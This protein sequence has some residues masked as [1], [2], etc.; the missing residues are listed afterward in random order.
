MPLLSPNMNVMMKAAEKAAKSLLRD[1]G[2]VENLQVSRKG[3]GDF[4]SAAD[5]RSEKIIFEELKKA[6]PDYGFLMEE[7]GKGESTGKE[8]FRWI[9]D[10]LDGTTNFLHGIPHWNITIALEYKD[11][12][13]AGLIFDPV[14]NELFH[15]EKGA[16]AFLRNQRLR[17]SSRTNIQ[18]AVLAT[19]IPTQGGSAQPAR[20]KFLNELQT[21]MQNQVSGVRRMGAAAL[22]MAYV[23]A[24]RY[25]GYWESSI[26]AWDV[27]AGTLIVREAGGFASPL[28]GEGSAVHSGS[29][30][31]ANSHLHA[32]LKKLLN[33]VVTETNAA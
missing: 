3:P 22:D 16:G 29:I 20:Q 2:E 27:A 33:S 28:H 25:E 17:V 1:F 21:V 24:G 12:I 15:A 30:L 32:P 7:R 18:D 13:I 26:N 10:P 14:K 6:R 19:G 8:D 9:V 31:A 11:E 5:L 23:A 4:V